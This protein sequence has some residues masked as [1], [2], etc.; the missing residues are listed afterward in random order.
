V[1]EASALGADEAPKPT[2]NDTGPAIA[3]PDESVPM[4]HRAAPAPS[5]GLGALIL[6]FVYPPKAS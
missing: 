1:V 3:A 6:D 5:G 4:P 2:A